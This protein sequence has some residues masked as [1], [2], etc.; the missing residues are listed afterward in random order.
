MNS[1]WKSLRRQKGGQEGNWWQKGSLWVWS[2]RKNPT[3]EKP[4][5]KAR[6]LM[7]Q[8]FTLIER[9]IDLSSRLIGETMLQCVVELMKSRFL[10]NH[11][12]LTFSRKRDGSTRKVEKFKPSCFELSIT[13]ERQNGKVD[14]L[15]PWTTRKFC[16]FLKEEKKPHQKQ[17]KLNVSF[18]WVTTTNRMR[19][20]V[21]G[22]KSLNDLALLTK[23]FLLES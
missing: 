16:R 9:F 15:R 23:I 10:C 11:Q 5:L 3:N 21:N 18:E 20:S 1:N 8:I 19:R 13:C 6:N 7:A 4:D 17:V 14:K 2:E 22:K 12:L